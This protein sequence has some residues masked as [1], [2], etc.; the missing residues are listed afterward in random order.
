MIP[1]LNWQHDTDTNLTYENYTHTN[2]DVMVKVQLHT[3]KLY[4]AIHSVYAV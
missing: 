2:S 4:Y 3:V 1:L